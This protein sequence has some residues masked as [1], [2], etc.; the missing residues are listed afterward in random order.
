M[1]G[2]KHDDYNFQILSKSD[3]W[4]LRKSI[5]SFG[6]L[7]WY[8]RNTDKVMNTGVALAS[9]GISVGMA[10]WGLAHH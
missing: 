9:N 7:S 6:T 2:H 1:L 4:L 3:E 8:Y 5:L 10:T